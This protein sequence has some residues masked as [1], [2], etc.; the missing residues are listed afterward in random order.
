[1]DVHGVCCTT[2]AVDSVTGGCCDSGATVD[3]AGRCCN[4]T[5]PVDACGVCGGGGVVVDVFGQ[6]CSSSLPPSGQCC[7]SG[8]VDACGVCDGTNACKMSLTAVLYLYPGTEWNTSIVDDDALASLIGVS[9]G[10]VSNST[11]AYDSSG[12]VYGDDGAYQPE[13]APQQVGNGCSPCC[14]S[15]ELFRSVLEW[16]G[17]LSIGS[18]A[19]RTRTC[20]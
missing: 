17:C 15:C 14:R 18:R 5:A 1:M 13:S 10:D 8:N 7:V 20:V 9:S 3:A 2:G 19:K 16:S 4:A 12:G 6:C 11:V